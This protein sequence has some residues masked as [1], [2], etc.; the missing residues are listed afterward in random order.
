MLD[1]VRKLLVRELRAL[2]RE[3]ELF[4][5]DESLWRTVPGLT[6]SAGNLVLHVCGNLKHFV[7]AILGHTGYVRDREREFAAREGSRADVLRQVEEAVGVVSDVL[8]R[9]PE[10]VLDAPYP[11]VHGGVQLS[12]R[13]FLLHLCTHAA[14]HLGQVGYARRV[15]TGSGVSSGPLSIGVL[16]EDR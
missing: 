7:G 6:N 12:G 1:D 5:D 2:G 11:E 8:A 3:V 14:F 9:L 10:D 4:P 16:A 13:L 15:V